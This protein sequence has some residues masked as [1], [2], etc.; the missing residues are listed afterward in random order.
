LNPVVQS[1]G[2]FDVRLSGQNSEGN[3]AAGV[4]VCFMGVRY[5]MYA[6]LMGRTFM[7][8]PQPVS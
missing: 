8:D 6:A 1:G 4:I 2:K 3:L 5:K 7:V